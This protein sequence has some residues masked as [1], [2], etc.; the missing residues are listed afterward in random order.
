MGYNLDRR[1]RKMKK[2]YTEATE[3]KRRV[4][5]M[6]CPDRSDASRR[7]FVT[8]EYLGCQS[9]DQIDYYTNYR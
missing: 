8:E 2:V 7:V 3:T 1:W 5:S 6:T 4:M 9:Q